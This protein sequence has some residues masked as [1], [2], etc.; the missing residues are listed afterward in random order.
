MSLYSKKTA[1]S[2]ISVTALAA[3]VPLACIPLAC[4]SGSRDDAPSRN[5]GDPDQEALSQIQEQPSKSVCDR[6]NLKPGF[7]ACHAKVRTEPSGNV[8]AFAT[9]SGFGPSDLQAAYKVP[10]GGGEG[11]IIAIV[12]AQ[13]DPKAEAD[14]GVYRSQFGL[15]SCTTAN[16]CFKKVNQD[17]K[18]SPLPAADDGWSGEIALDLDMASAI[19]PECKILL[20]EANSASLDDLGKAVNTAV[21]LGATVVSNSYGGSEDSTESQADTDYYVHPGVGIFA[22][23]GDNGYGTSYPAASAGVISVG[24]TSLTKSSSTRGWAES[25]WNGAGSG[26]S[27]YISKPSWQTDTGCSKKVMGD[28]S[29][30]ADPNTGVAVYVTQGASGWA[31]YGGTSASSPIVASIYAKTGHGGDNGSYV[32]THT[33]NFYDVTS[34][35]NGSCSPSYL[36]KGTAGYDGPTGWGSPNA[37][38]LAGGGGGTDAGTGTDSGSG[39]TCAHNVCS[40]GAKL[41]KSCSAC[42]TAVCNNDSYCCNT[43]WD[44]YCVSEVADYCDQTCN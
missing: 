35:S 28:V 13:D 24:G 26:C 16:G 39:G 31:V 11:K 19:C 29:A 33:G 21:S 10:S 7:A 1:V 22:S 12:D 42:A 14:L 38:A 18:A 41:T 30:V 40:T 5:V 37:T 44:N 6:T 9:P 27:K 3:L 23:T 36:C 4:S 20:V 15:S 32:W 34:G 2:F 43:A 25:V 8:K 17:G